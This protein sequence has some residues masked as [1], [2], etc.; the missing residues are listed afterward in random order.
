MQRICIQRSPGKRGK[1]PSV[2]KKK[3]VAITFKNIANP[4]A[5]IRVVANIKNFD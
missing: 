5:F 4:F 2:K 1:G 3:F